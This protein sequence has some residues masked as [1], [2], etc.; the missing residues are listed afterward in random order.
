MWPVDQ[1]LMVIR[2]KAYTKSYINIPPKLLFP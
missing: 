2:F 1:D